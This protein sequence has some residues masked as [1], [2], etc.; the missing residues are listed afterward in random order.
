MRDFD[1]LNA[2]LGKRERFPGGRSLVMDMDRH[3]ARHFGS[4]PSGSTTTTQTNQPW[5]GEMPYLTDIYSQSQNLDQT[6][7]PQYYPSDTYSGLTGQQTG[8]MSNLIDYGSGG[9]NS[10]LNAANSNLTSALSPGYT[11]GTTG[12]F[13]QGQG[14]LSNE[15]SSSFLN[16]TT[17]PGYETAMSNAMASAIPA[18]TASFVNGNRSDGGLAQAASTSAAT[19]AA[20]GLAANEYNTLLN[21]QNQAA[22]QAA[23]NL[24]TQQGNQ[25]KD[26]LTAPMVDQA[27]SGDLATALNTAGMTQTN[28][29]NELNAKISAYNY[30]QMQPWNQLGLYENAVT[31]LGNTGSQSTTSQPYFSNPL[32]NITSAASGLGSLGMLGMM[33]F[34]DERLKEDIHKI[35]ESDS[36]FPLYTFRYKWEGP[37]SMH[38]GVMAQ[39]V[40]KSRPEAVIHTPHGMMVDYI[41]ALAA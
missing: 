12:A 3:R 24:L 33:A 37:M 26:L 38:I 34:S 30:G 14:V 31:G 9:G 23:S 7:T 25:T 35:G 36:G 10:G 19:N 18:A 13:N 4:S 6:A 17:I 27:Q 8:L 22:G 41:Q 29:Q 32:A 39:D 15:M 16:P 20:G 40:E 11:A 2:G 5:S 28:A 21:T 1:H